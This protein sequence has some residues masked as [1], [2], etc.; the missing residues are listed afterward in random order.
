MNHSQKKNLV[1]WTDHYKNI[2]NNVMNDNQK[3]QLIERMYLYED[4]N[5]EQHAQW[6]IDTFGFTVTAEECTS[7]FLHCMTQCFNK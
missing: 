6:A 4:D 7:I 1:D 2:G 3:K 5:F